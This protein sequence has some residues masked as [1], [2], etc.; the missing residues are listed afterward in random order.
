MPVRYRTCSG[1][2]V[3]VGGYSKDFEAYQQKLQISDLHYD[4]FT[5][6]SNVC[7]LE[8]KIQKLRY[9]LAHI[10]L[11]KLCCG[12]KKWRWLTQW[13][14]SNLRALSE[15]FKCRILKYSIRKIASA[16]NRIIHNTIHL[17][18]H[19][20]GTSLHEFF[21]CSS[22]FLLQLVSFTVDSNPLQPTEGEDRY[23]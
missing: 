14:I 15:E 13:M 1:I 23:T 16:L 21:H 20:G 17:Q 10:F 3:G 2:S 9:A 12:S 6:T 4:K 5:T 8:D 11:R 18:A 7:L 22:L 19:R